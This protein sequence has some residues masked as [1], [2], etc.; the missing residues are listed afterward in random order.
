MFYTLKKSPLNKHVIT[1]G[2]YNAI[3]NTSYILLLLHQK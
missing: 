2:G 1:S 3:A